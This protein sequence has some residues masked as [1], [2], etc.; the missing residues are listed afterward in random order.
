MVTQPESA[1]LHDLAWPDTGTATRDAVTQH[2]ATPLATTLATRACDQ[3]ATHRT[4][5]I[6]K[7]MF[8]SPTANDTLSFLVFGVLEGNTHT[9]THMRAGVRA[10]LFSL[11]VTAAR[12]H[13]GRATT[14]ALTE[15]ERS[16]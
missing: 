5:S 16:L 1:T 15:G 13:T 8:S 3:L 9:H 12:A 2:S 7:S 10:L 4:L 14:E 6:Y 11:A